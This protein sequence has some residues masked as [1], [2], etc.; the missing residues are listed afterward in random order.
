M[1]LVSAKWES[2]GIRQDIPLNQLE[3]WKV[4]FLGDAAKCWVKVMEHWL[5]GGGLPDYPATWDGLYLLLEDVECTEVAEKLK[6]FVTT[7]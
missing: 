6:K 1:N 5:S 2:F 7:L 4:E 3:G